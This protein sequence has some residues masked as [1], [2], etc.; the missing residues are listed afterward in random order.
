M[1]TSTPTATPT[2]TEVAIATATT[3]PPLGLAGDA[4][5]DGVLSSIDAA[6]V[7]QVHAGLLSSVGCPVNA[8]ID[9]DSEIT[10]LDAAIVLQLVAE[11]F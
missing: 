2:R 1:P 3:T 9:G 11:L 4:N 8:D 5:C 6:L 10:S 7:L